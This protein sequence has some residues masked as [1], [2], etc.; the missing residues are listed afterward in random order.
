MVTFRADEVGVNG[1]F[2]VSQTITRTA[3]DKQF[4]KYIFILY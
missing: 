3:D 1:E 4:I 2:I